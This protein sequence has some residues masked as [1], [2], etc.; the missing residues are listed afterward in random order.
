MSLSAGT[1]RALAALLAREGYT[2]AA[3]VVMHDMQGPGPY[4]A[5]RQ[6]RPP[7]LVP[8]LV[9][10][11]AG[12]VDPEAA[13]PDVFV[14]HRSVGVSTMAWRV[15]MAPYPDEALADAERPGACAASYRPPH[16]GHPGESSSSSLPFGGDGQDVPGS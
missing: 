16:G 2:L 5:H 1:R 15:A 12:Y 14:K 6:W 9:P 7:E 13:Y 4:E 3:F 11:V 8:E 10:V